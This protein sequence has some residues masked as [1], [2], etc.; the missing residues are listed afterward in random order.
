MAAP[1]AREVSE[2][3]KFQPD[4]KQLCVLVLAVAL[5]VVS[6][7]VPLDARQPPSPTAVTIASA[8]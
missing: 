3:S 1:A 5:A 2:M 8:R 7:L 6:L 4:S